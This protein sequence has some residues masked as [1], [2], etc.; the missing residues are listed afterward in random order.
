MT[1]LRLATFNCENLFSRPKVL[2]HA[3]N[4]AGRAP[5]NRL[6][7]LDAV[8]LTLERFND[9][10][11]KGQSFGFE[12]AYSSGPSSSRNVASASRRPASL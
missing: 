12:R 4:E 6:A 1:K 7:K 8:L 2:N 5:L 3:D 9:S 11:L 10:L